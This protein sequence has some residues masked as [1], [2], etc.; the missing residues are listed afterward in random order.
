MNDVHESEQLFRACKETGFF[1]LDLIGS[2]AGETMLDDA[3]NGFDLNQKSF[4]L[5]QEELGKFLFRP[6]ESL[7]GHVSPMLSDQ[8][9][10]VYDPFCKLDRI[11]TKGN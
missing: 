6:K 5:E 2:S 1:L 11:Q 8:A 10:D 4:G 7:Y 9:S 3:A